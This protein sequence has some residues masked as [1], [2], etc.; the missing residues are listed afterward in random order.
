MKRG[1]WRSF[2]IAA[3]A[4]C[5]GF[6]HAQPA[7]WTIKNGTATVILFGS[8][9]VLPPGLDWAPP[10]LSEALAK[11][12][13]VWFELPM[14]AATQSRVGELARARGL[15]PAGKHLSDDLDRKQNKRLTRDAAV[16]GVSVQAL[17]TMRPWLADVLLSLALDG[18]SGAAGA[19]GVET[20]AQASA[21]VGAARHA[22]ETPDDQID[23]LAGAADTDQRAALQ[24]TLDDI[25]DHNDLY[26]R[27]V[28]AWMAG[29][30]ASLQRDVLGPLQVK[31]PAL[32]ARLIGDRNQRWVAILKERLRHPGLIVVIV[33]TGHLIGP[34]GVPAALRAQGFAVEGP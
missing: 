4:I 32:Y 33:G 1:F 7:M 22:F 14:D 10:A 34:Q 20:W 29:D 15:W 18:E 16:V 27:L 21:R 3:V 30:L 11:A 26:R 13:E 2:A 12:D 25:E 5:G 23:V 17:Q 6:A 24:S 9:H 19:N 28:N 8:I 31:T